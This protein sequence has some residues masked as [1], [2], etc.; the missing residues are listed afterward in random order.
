MKKVNKCLMGMLFLTVTKF[1]YGAIDV[2]DYVKE[3]FN[4]N[5]NAGGIAQ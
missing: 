2:P 3:H 1:I 5:D 4:S